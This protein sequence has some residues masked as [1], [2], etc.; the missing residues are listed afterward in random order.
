MVEWFRYIWETE[1]L[2]GMFK[3][4]TMNIFKVK[5]S[6]ILNNSQGSHCNRNKYDGE[7]RFEQST[8]QKLSS[9]TLQITYANTYL[10]VQ[11]LFCIYL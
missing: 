6:I 4:V 11:K 9:L 2:R 3:G 5:N 8:R 1:G 7:E 10:I